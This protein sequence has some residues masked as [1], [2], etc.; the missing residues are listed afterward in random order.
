MMILKNRLIVL[1][2]AYTATLKGRGL[3]L[4]LN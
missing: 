2:N 1:L 3:Y 4:N